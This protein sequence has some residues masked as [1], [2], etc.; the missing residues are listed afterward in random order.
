MHYEILVED[1]SG[2]RV[3]EEVVPKILPVNCT[4]SIFHYKGI[5]HIPKGLQPRLDPSKRVLLNQL[6]RILAGY[7]KKFAS[8]PDNYRACVVVICDL[9]NRNFKDFLAELSQILFQC[10][11][12]PMGRFCLCIEEGEAWL[13]GHREA[14][15]A[16]YPDA[17]Q[18]VL[19]TYVPDSICGTWEVLADAVYQGGSTALLAK[20]KPEVGRMKSIW[21]VDIAPL[22]D[23]EEN[24]SPSFQY[25]ARSLQELK[26]EG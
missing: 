8:Y 24:K 13:L 3:L 17:K 21:A 7:G 19:D 10:N 25:F 9:D 14:V 22:L 4:F 6:P 11:P 15:E 1:Q 20:G 12:R 2:K 18:F 16:A 26:N 23:V 5:G